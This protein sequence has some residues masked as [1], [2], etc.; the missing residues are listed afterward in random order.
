[1]AHW[2][3]LTY[4]RIWLLNNRLTMISWEPWVSWFTV[5]SPQFLH[6]IRV[7][8]DES[9]LLSV[10]S[11]SS[12]TEAVW[13]A[14]VLRST[15]VCPVSTARGQRRDGCITIILFLF[16]SVFTGSEYVTAYRKVIQTIYICV[17]VAENRG[18]GCRGASAPQ[19]YKRGPHPPI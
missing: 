11:A 13:A 19:L 7:A 10:V 5:K 8:E 17:T 1:M 16:T 6:R 2:R 4:S 3:L 14:I 18:A 12:A 9:S 15:Y